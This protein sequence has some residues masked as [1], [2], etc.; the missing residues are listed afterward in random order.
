MRRLVELLDELSFVLIYLEG[1]FSVFR[2]LLFP[3]LILLVFFESLAG[4]DGL[5]LEAHVVQLRLSRASFFFCC[6]LC[7]LC[8]FL[9]LL[10]FDLFLLLIVH[11]L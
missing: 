1:S 6:E 8:V 11:E 4:Y 7:P 5:T 9:F 3:E 2:L 10:F